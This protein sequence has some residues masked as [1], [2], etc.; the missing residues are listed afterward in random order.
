M[1][2]AGGLFLGLPAGCSSGPEDHTFN[3][4]LVAEALREAWP[5]SVE[6]VSISCPGAGRLVLV[7]DGTEYALNG[8]AKG[9]GYADI[10]P[11]WLPDPDNPGAKLDIGWLIRYGNVE[12][13]YP[14]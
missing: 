9:A 8:T 13:G 12:C 11:L 4:P 2:V 5:L 6:E 10:D 1:I 14:A 3:G 7:S